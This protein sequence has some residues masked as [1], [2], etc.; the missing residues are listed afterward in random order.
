MLKYLFC[1]LYFVFKKQNGRIWFFFL[2]VVFP[3]RI[4]GSEIIPGDFE[5]LKDSA[6]ELN[7]LGIKY[8]YAGDLPRAKMNLDK[9]LE[10]RYQILDSNDYSLASTLGN[11]GNWSSEMGNL[12]L[13]LNYY[14]RAERIF[15]ENNSIK[16]SKLGLSILYEN[17]GIIYIRKG[18]YTKALSYL[19]KSLDYFENK[20]FESND[21]LY[22]VKKLA[23]ICRNIGETYALLKDDIK[24]EEYL[25]RSIKLAENYSDEIMFSPMRELA[26]LYLSNGE[27]DKA[28]LLY[29]KSIKNVKY[30]YNSTNPHLIRTYLSLANLF[31]ELEDYVKSE[32]YVDSAFEVILHQDLVRPVMRA[33]C[34]F[35]WGKL[36]SQNKEPDSAIYFYNRGL[37]SLLKKPMSYEEI[38]LNNYDEIISRSLFIDCLKE[39]S[40]VYETRYNATKS[41]DELKKSLFYLDMVIHIIQDSKYGFRSEESKYSI[42]ENE[43]EVYLKAIDLCYMLYD[44]TGD[45][46]MLSKI[47]EYS[48][49]NKS[50]ILL[51]EIRNMEAF[52]YSDIPLEMLQ[53]EREL[54]HSISAYINLEHAEN[55]SMTK[56]VKKLKLYDS[57]LFE[58]TKEYD[59]LIDD[60]E[61]SYPDYYNLKYNTNVI[62]LEEI[63]TQLKSDEA[64][65]E[66]ISGDSV[67]YIM[68]VTRKSTFITKQHPGSHYLSYLLGLLDI[69]KHYPD[70]K[71]VNDEY[72]RFQKYALY[73]YNLLFDPVNELVAGKKLFIIPDEQ[74]YY[75]PFDVLIEK[76]NN[77]VNHTDYKSLAYLL[78]KFNISY[79][80]SATLLL[81]YPGYHRKNYKDSF[82]AFAPDYAE[83]GIV[84]HSNDY[85]KRLRDSIYAI[86]NAEKEIKSLNKI[87][88]GKIF[89][90]DRATEKNFRKYAKNT[91]IIHLAMHTIL[92]EQNPLFSKLVFQTDSSFDGF[93]NTYEL[94]NLKINA[95]LAVLSS[96]NTGTGKLFKGEGIGSLSR[97]FYYA[98][99][100]GMVI[101][102][103]KISDY[104]THKLMLE[105]YSGL[106]RG[107]NTSGALRNAKLNFLK[108][109]DKLTSH[110]FFWSSFVLIGEDDIIFPRMFVKY[111]IS[112]IVI[113][114]AALASIWVFMNRKRRNKIKFN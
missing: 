12:D 49:K 72:Y 25:K 101:T 48:E 3:G 20:E 32:H 97:G 90:K 70:S 84:M 65:L 98:G 68:V 17:F 54:K 92:N 46:Q 96:C 86:E 95:K 87:L 53:R 50:S 28:K 56:D 7:T 13:A 2:L 89:I 42:S 102:L 39:L 30:Y 52:E 45:A 112:G 5:K 33:E 100:P 109:S 36:A 58:L 76:K 40:T 83:K 16:R 73:L 6:L 82:I 37:Q 108:E 94:Y 23:I 41:L 62:S 114:L 22:P 78:K 64:L 27:F 99:C 67:M 18:E 24:A 4:A 106:I 110:P 88:H 35:Q 8:L 75:L 19:F 38:I 57:L 47:F 107:K 111:A 26:N 31:S 69:I 77:A 93:L 71:G 1:I 104:A 15:L 14:Y 55:L 9:A 63:K 79:G 80:Y 43:K 34:F 103:W 105:F 21:S 60:F 81:N 113:I 59:K 66:Y 74:L 10:I 91:K 44:I 11:L 51:S 29:E 85:Y 61:V